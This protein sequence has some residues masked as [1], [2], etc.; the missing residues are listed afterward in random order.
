MNLFY[1]RHIRHI[2][3]G[4]CFALLLSCGRDTS[5]NQR[6]G[7][8]GQNRS[9]QVTSVEVATVETASISDQIRSF[10]TVRAQD[11]VEI[12]PQVSNRITAIHADLGDTVSQGQVMA[13]IYDITFRDE[14]EQ[15]Q[16]QMRQSR[17]AFQRDST[18]F[19]RQQSLYE[20]NAI[21]SSEFE[22]AQ[23]A[24]ESS[25]AQFEAASAAL[26][27]SRENLANTDIRS[28]VDGVV[29]NR[30]I[31]EG[32]IAT[33]GTPAFEVAN[34]V[35]YETRLFLPMQDWE[36]VS[37]GLPVEM[38]LSN[39][40]GFAAGG[41]I[42]RISPHLNPE[43]GLGEV[44]VSLTNV[45]PSI[46]QGVLVDSRITLVTHENAVVIPRSAMIEQV[47]T[48]IEP[49]TNSVELRRTY[50]VFVAAADTVAEQR[51]ITPGL[52]QGE[53]IEV[54]SGLEEGDRLIVTGQRSLSDSSE[55]RIAGRNAG[56]EEQSIG[57]S[58]GE[59][60]RRGQEDQ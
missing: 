7:G 52:E 37:V 53:R 38:R 16:A 31:A 6:S 30:L 12:S 40:D 35:G 58:G 45:T 29:L 8:F 14:F 32:D 15:A 44:V 3:I 20:S 57:D 22:E 24:Y 27:Q 5:D 41:N 34:L 55:I 17:S 39:R 21:S 4:I 9:G 50:S 36:Q 47:E 28:P 51:T 59:N 43:T 60:S 11:V 19:E 46:R 10:G 42:S 2:L 49:E 25:R 26:T 48:Y 23:A 56:D 13:Q 1:H 54:L 33:T 18:N